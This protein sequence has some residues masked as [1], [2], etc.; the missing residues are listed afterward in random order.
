[1][2]LPSVATAAAAR[3][4]KAALSRGWLHSTYSGDVVEL[5]RRCSGRWGRCGG[6]IREISGGSRRDLGEIG[7]R[8]AALHLGY[9]ARQAGP[10]AAARAGEAQR[11]D[12]EAAERGDEERQ[13]AE[14]L[15]RADP[16]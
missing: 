10:E 9:V 8:L 4:A 3:E 13:A 7:E 2:P 16:T 14:S 5:K 15:A 12:D 1:M 11:G 6:D